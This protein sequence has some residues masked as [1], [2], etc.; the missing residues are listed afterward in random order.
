M[1]R[2][3]HEALLNFGNDRR[4]IAPGFS[5]PWREVDGYSCIDSCRAAVDEKWFE[6]PKTYRIDRQ[7][8]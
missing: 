5:H 4:G 1:T 7:L 8:T 2:K 6:L 3:S